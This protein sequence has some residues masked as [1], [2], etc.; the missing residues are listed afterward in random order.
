MK[1]F[2]TKKLYVI[3]CAALLVLG[4]AG[5]S[6]G[7]GGWFGSKDEDNSS[8]GYTQSYGSTNGRGS[9]NTETEP[10]SVPEPTTVILLGVGLAGLAVYKWRS[11]K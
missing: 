10:V 6:F 7:F 2:Q 1:N 3:L 4:T 9:G 5:S 8:G 11:K